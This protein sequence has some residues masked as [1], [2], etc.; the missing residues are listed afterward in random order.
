M[1]L[2]IYVCGKNSIPFQAQSEKVREKAF[3][4]CKE[5]LQV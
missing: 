1:D 4:L 3:A 5:Y 2:K